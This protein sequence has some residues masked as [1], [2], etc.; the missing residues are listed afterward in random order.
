MCRRAVLLVKTLFS[1]FY[2]YVLG[3]QKDREKEGR[4]Y[5]REIKIEREEK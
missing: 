1:Q 2:L 5:K 4:E 3:R